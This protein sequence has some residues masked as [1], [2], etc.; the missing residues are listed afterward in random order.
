MPKRWW[1]SFAINTVTYHPSTERFTYRLTLLWGLWL[2]LPFPTFQSARGLSVLATLASESMWAA[3]FILVG[4]KLRRSC[5]IKKL[6]D[7]RDSMFGAFILWLLTTCTIIVSNPIGTGTVV[8]G[9]IVYIIWWGYIT[10]AERYKYRS[11][12]Q[13]DTL[14]I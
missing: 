11:M 4:W 13:D 10:S 5:K 14:T 9:F 1:R 2:A 8:Y 7:I 6:K 3:L 12:D